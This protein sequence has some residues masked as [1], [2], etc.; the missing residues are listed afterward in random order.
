M[1]APQ[2]FSD[3]EKGKKSKDTQNTRLDKLM[4]SFQKI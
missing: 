4:L 3:E 1:K 2:L